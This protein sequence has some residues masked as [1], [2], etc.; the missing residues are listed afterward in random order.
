MSTLEPAS[1]NQAAANAAADAIRATGTSPGA[2]A[3]G[4]LP[5]PWRAWLAKAFGLTCEVGQAPLTF[6]SDAAVFSQPPSLLG[7][8]VESENHPDWRCSFETWAD[9]SD[10]S[11]PN[12]WP[13]SALLTV[14]DD[15]SDEAARL[16]G[17]HGY[18][19][20]M[21][22]ATAQKGHTVVMAIQSNRYDGGTPTS[23]A[24]RT[25]SE[26]VRTSS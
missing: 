6:M 20:R 5:P 13:G 10:Q 17:P 11:G 9:S 26:A 12:T 19:Y 22:H 4:Q 24:I 25:I 8:T 23:F 2:R 7:D 18:L 3:I 21:A 15:G 14:L 16:L 1:A